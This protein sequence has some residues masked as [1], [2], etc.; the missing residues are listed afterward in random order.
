LATT[1]YF[2]IKS[3]IPLVKFINAIVEKYQ[4]KKIKSQKFS[5][6]YLDTFDWRIYRSNSLLKYIDNSLQ[7]QKFENLK[8]SYEK[9]ISNLPVFVSDIPK[10]NI[11]N[12]I[13][14]II[15]IR[16]LRQVAS[17]TENRN[18]YNVLDNNEKIILKLQ[19]NSIN[20]V[21]RFISLNAVR[22]YEKELVSFN[23]LINSLVSKTSQKEIYEKILK[24][25]K[26]MPADYY[27]RMQ[28]LLKPKMRSDEAIKII[29][30]NLNDILRKNEQGIIDDIDTEF[31]HDFRVACRRTR[32]VLSQIKNVFE[33]GYTEKFNKHFTSLGKRTN[34]LRDL[35]VYLLNKEKYVNRLP[36]NMK[37]NIEPFFSQLLLI[38][39]IEHKNLCRYLK[40]TTYKN[41]AQN[42]NNFLS[43]KSNDPKKAVNAGKPV[44]NLAMTNIAKQY[45]KVMDLGKKISPESKDIF[46][47][48]LRIQCKKLRYLLE[49]FSSL[50][51]KEKINV[52][53]SHLKILQDN[54]GLFNDLSV[55]QEA[56]RNYSQKNNFNNDVV[57]ALGY[58]IGKL[59]AEQID[60]RKDFNNAYQEFS[61]NETNKIFKELFANESGGK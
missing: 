5:V 42:W 14:K 9:E 12:A 22:G 7:L 37:K 3:N 13:N 6:I 28:V 15:Q 43:D 36:R 61:N 48:K 41:Q 52:L 1:K 47:H 45:N 57:L 26:I 4:I 18:E 11:K 40:S 50:F 54:L 53:I 35:D 33:P 17:I 59:N 34:K 20:Q 44:I 25:N 8:P 29:L 49:F 58:L 23:S 51:P 55:Q 27:P 31:L 46:Y 38:R 2:Q 32:A 16:A 30:R 39:N 24:S 21:G 19:V 56:L 60:V 10:S